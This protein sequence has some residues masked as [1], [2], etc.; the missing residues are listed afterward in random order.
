MNIRLMITRPRQNRSRSHQSLPASI[1]MITGMTP[2]VFTVVNMTAP[3][4]TRLSLIL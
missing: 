2:L 1:A 3:T 4:F